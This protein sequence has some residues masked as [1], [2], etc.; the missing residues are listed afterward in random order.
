MT[1]ENARTKARSPLSRYAPAL[2]GPAGRAGRWVRRQGK[3]RIGA[4]VVIL[5]ALVAVIWWGTATPGGSEPAVAESAQPA[6]GTLAGETPSASASRGPLPLEGVS[7]LDFQLGDCFKDFD[8]EALQS[9]IVD[10]GTEHSAQLVAVESYPEPEAY[11]GREP[12]KQ[13]ALDACKA[14]DLTAKAADYTLGYKLAYPST[15]SWD[16]GDR[17]VD[18]YVIAETGNVIM[19]TLL[20]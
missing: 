2:A 13:K 3:R 6:S 12:L 16:K 14:A 20:P 10:C 9:T 5:L 15:T 4:G 18:C 11:P 19:E 8:P 7:A 17:R 1:D